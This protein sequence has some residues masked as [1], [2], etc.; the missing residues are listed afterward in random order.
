M[1]DL[2]GN[3][4]DRFSHDEAHFL[5]AYLQI[6]VNPITTDGAIAILRAVADERCRSLQHLDLSV[7]FFMSFVKKTNMYSGISA[8]LNTNPPT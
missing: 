7:C 3:P 4:E 5:H 1:S 6:G 8:R 2:V